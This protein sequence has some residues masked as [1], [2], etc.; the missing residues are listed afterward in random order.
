VNL[1]KRRIVAYI[2][3]KLV[4]GKEIYRVFDKNTFSFNKI[5]GEVS[6]SKI[7]VYDTE[8]NELMTGNGDDKGISLYDYTTAKIIDL[9]IEAENFQ[10]FDYES[11]KLFFG[12]MRENTVSF[13]DFQTSKHYYYVMMAEDE[14]ISENLGLLI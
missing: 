12:D 8:R 2:V 10:G 7:N 5:A 4:G 1:Y 6:V 3:G 14:N 9:K 11:K 13:F